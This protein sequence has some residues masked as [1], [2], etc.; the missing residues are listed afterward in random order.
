MYVAINNIPV[1]GGK[2]LSC[3]HSK[4]DILLVVI[5]TFFPVQ[6]CLQI[7]PYCSLIPNTPS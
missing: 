3:L 6:H 4:D 2:Y 1:L 7:D 5:K